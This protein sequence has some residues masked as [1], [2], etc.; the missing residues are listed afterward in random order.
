MINNTLLRDYCKLGA[1]VKPCN[2][3]LSFDLCIYWAWDYCFCFVGE[4]IKAWSHQESCSYYTGI[5]PAPKVRL[6]PSFT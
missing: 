2:D 4:K 1:V 3:V 6:F 5:T